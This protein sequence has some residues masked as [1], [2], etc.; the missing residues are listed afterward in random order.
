[1]TS[2]RRVAGFALLSTILVAACAQGVSEGERQAVRRWLA[3]IEPCPAERLAVQSIGPDAIGLLV[4]PLD[5]GSWGGRVFTR[6]LEAS[7]RGSLAALPPD[8]G[9]IAAVRFYLGN[10]LAASQIQAAIALGNL[11]ATREIQNALDERDSR[12]L[13]PDV[14]RALQ[15][16]LA[17]TTLGGPPPADSVVVIP[18]SLEMQ[19]GRAMTLS[20]LV[21]DPAGSQLANETVTWSLMSGSSVVVLDPGGRVTALDTGQAI[22][23]ATHGPTKHE[24]RATVRVV[25]P[26]TRPRLDVVSGDLQSTPIGS[27]LP[28]AVVVRVRTPDGTVIPGAAVVWSVASGGGALVSFEA[29]A[30]INGLA[31]ARWR[32]GDSVGSQRLQ[33]SGPSG[34]PLQVRAAA[35]TTTIQGVIVNDR[36][37]DGNTV[38]PDEALAGAVV[39]LYK[40]GSGVATVA[41]DSLVATDT[42]DAGGVFR[43]TGLPAGT[44][45]VRPISGTPAGRPV[46]VLR[47]SVNGDT[48]I[49]RTAGPEPAPGSGNPDATLAPGTGGRVVGMTSGFGGALPLP[50]WDYANSAM[51]LK[52]T[53]ALHR[54]PHFTFLFGNGSATVTVRK[55]GTAVAGVTVSAVRCSTA[56]GFTSPPT[57]GVGTCTPM[58]SATNGTTDTAGSWTFNGLRE[59]VWRISVDPATVGLPDPVATMLVVLVGNSDVETANFVFP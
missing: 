27:E 19:V 15:S 54:Q 57:I 25:P 55:A 7:I 52:R 48:A 29:L 40:D 53:G 21:L 46:L 42:T 12:G 24:G 10:A 38:D 5:T 1:M 14:V 35:V 4:Q 30:D 33:V 11:R 41:A 39:E 47:D 51:N 36:D 28:A 17:Y 45:V 56:S 18:D 20:F 32:L 44:Y 16:A 49:V 37:A 2:C 3:C 31:R 8:S 50:A 23:V 9:T 13:R 26:A 59:G 34:L 22:V 58:G 6:A 43:F